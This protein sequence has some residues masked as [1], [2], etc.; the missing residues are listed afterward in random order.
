MS[1]IDCN[2]AVQR[3]KFGVP[4]VSL[5]RGFVQGEGHGVVIIHGAPSSN[6]Q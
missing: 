5:L 3:K 2:P 4:A 6:N 1:A